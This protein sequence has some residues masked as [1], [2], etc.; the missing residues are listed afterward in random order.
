MH[1][2]AGM[3]LAGAHPEL[4]KLPAQQRAVVFGM[5]AQA[6]PCKFLKLATLL[7]KMINTHR[8]PAFR[9][10]NLINDGPQW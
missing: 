1:R 8:A 6:L 2:R 3:A 7:S 10:V 4:H 5:L 9:G